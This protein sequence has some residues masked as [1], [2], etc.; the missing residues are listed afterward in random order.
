METIVK[1]EKGDLFYVATLRRETKIQ[2]PPRSIFSMWLATLNNSPPPLFITITCLI[3]FLKK[4]GSTWFNGPMRSEML[5]LNT[6]DNKLHDQE[7]TKDIWISAICSKLIPE[8]EERWEGPAR[9]AL[10]LLFR[11]NTLGTQRNNLC[12]RW[13]QYTQRAHHSRNVMFARETSTATSI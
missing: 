5:T 11:R 13:S 9:Q 3:V 6:S 1:A 8:A 10:T 2:L 7:G 4:S 12:H